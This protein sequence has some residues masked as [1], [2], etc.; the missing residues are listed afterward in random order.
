MW[1][2]ERNLSVQKD[3][4]MKID[5]PDDQRRQVGFAG[6]MISRL[7]EA[8]TFYKTTEKSK[9]ETNFIQK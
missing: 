5:S 1:T 9:V 7:K 8:K 2:V 3:I 4:E 6:S